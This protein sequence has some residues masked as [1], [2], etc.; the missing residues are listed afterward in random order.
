MN[1]RLQKCIVDVVIFAGEPLD[2][3]GIRLNAKKINKFEI[4]NANDNEIIR[5][6]DL[7]IDEKALFVYSDRSQ[8]KRYYCYR[9]GEWGYYISKGGF[10]KWVYWI[11]YKNNNLIAFLS[12]LLSALALLDFFKK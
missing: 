10:R 3:N 8:D 12:L 2:L 11:I 6:I 9:V 5:Q 1:T 7:L 4:E